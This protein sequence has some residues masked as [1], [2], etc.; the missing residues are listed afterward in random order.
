MIGDEERLQGTDSGAVMLNGEHEIR[1]IL[2]YVKY[3]LH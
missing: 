2:Q 1:M 3:I